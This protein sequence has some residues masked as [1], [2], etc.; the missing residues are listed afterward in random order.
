MIYPL[1]HE[2]EIKK[3]VQVLLKYGLMM[4]YK[5]PWAS[6]AFVVINPDG[7]RR[8]VTNLEWIN[9]QL[10]SNSYPAPS[11]P[12]M[13]NKFHGKTIFSTFD[14]I[15][16]LHNVLVAEESRKYTAF[17]TKCD[18]FVWKVMPFGVRIVPLSG[19]ENLI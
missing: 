1:D 14:I 13:I 3:T 2:D 7:S 6:K 10:Y 9:D 12:D 11:V 15:K 8:M 18:T 19:P 17:T 16:A 5:G 4:P